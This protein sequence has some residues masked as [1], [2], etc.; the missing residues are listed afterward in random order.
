MKSIIYV[1]VFTW[2]VFSIALLNVALWEI[3]MKTIIMG[4]GGSITA[5]VFGVIYVKQD[6]K[7]MKKIE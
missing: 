1:L 5:L 6:L 4:L 7:E 2:I 3:T